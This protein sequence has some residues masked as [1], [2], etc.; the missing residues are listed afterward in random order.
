MEPPD[1]ITYLDYRRFL[2]DWFDWK[3]ADN[4][5]YSHRL[6]AR[7]AG[8]RSPSLL[9][10][11]SE[12]KRNLTA[13]TT[14]GFCDAMALDEPS[15]RHFSL[16]VRMDQAETSAERAEALEEILATKR[17]REARRLE[18]GGFQY[19]AHWW[20]PAIHELARRTDFRPDPAW[21]AA[22]LDPP[23]PVDRAAQALEALLD[24]GLLA[25]DDEGVPRPTDASVVTP[26][27]VADVAIQAYHEGMLRR[28]VESIDRFPR[29]QRHL[30]G[31]TVAIP[32]SLVPVVKARLNEVQ[33]ELLSLC[34]QPAHEQVY[35]L[36][37]A[38]FPLT[39]QTSEE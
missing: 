22:Q 39:N 30:L 8:V 4:S 27:E 20:F 34:D 29:S 10:L 19:M 23:V 14:Q 18:A 2:R 1:V 7:R 36:S 16:L 33:R 21:I 25:P 32:G 6:F 31:L 26:H 17:F 13:Q 15:T 24:I 12:G 38:F 35:Q 3:K 11:V 37:I 28:A 9:L 5:R